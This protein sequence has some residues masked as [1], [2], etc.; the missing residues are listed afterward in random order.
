[1][2]NETSLTGQTNNQWLHLEPAAPTDNTGTTSG[3]YR[4]LFAIWRDISVRACCRRFS[5][6]SG[7]VL[8]LFK[9]I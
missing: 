5:P 1:M 9:Y 4:E 3:A 6:K 7:S 2:P 8:N